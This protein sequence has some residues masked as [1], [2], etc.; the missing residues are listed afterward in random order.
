MLITSSRNAFQTCSDCVL[1]SIELA[2][3]CKDRRTNTISKQSKIN[4]A[5][6]VDLFKGT[7]ST[8]VFLTV[9]RL[10]DCFVG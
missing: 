8:G 6:S 7:T 2:C 9:N 5:A 10:L 1:S 4:L 3:R